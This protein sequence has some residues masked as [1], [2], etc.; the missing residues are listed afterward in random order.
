MIIILVKAAL[1]IG[2]GVSVFMFAIF[3][4]LIT[5]KKPQDVSGHHLILSVATFACALVLPYLAGAM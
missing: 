3:I 5:S 4:G 2:A 1:M